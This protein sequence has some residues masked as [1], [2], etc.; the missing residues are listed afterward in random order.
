[1]RRW[2][3]AGALAVAL[4]L[5]PAAP[6]LAADVMVMT[7]GAFR[8]V[9]QDV[10]PEIERETGQ[11]LVIRNGTSGAVADAV[12]A[13]AALDLVVLPPAAGEGLGALL[14]PLRPLA[15]VGIGVAVRAGAPRPD[16]STPEAVRASVLAA[17]A[18]AW[19]DPAAGGSSGIYLAG[20]WRSWGIA[21][22]LASRA[23]L[24]KGGLV[25]DS[26]RDGRA[27]LGFQQLSELTGIEGVEV[28]GAL[29]GSIQSYTVYAGAVPAGSRAPEAAA[30]VLAL[31][32]GPAAAAALRARGMEAP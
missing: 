31:L 9:L 20:L 32:S 1:M 21:E 29:P 2:R 14:G 10:A 5:R 26:L 24:A 30:Q 17:R 12:R 19:I 11:H 6:A 23:V 13:G 28:V 25:A 7:A 4:L 15:K 8:A 27:D 18:P 22:A 16:I 3:L